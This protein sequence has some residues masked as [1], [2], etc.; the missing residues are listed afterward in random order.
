MTRE[1]KTSVN[2]PGVRTISDDELDSIAGGSMMDIV[3]RAFADYL[4]NC[5]FKLTREGTVAVCPLPK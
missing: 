5:L 4:K 2:V 3:N 1:R